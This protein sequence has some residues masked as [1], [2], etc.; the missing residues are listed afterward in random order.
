MKLEYLREL[1]SKHRKDPNYRLKNTSEEEFFAQSVKSYER[2]PEEQKK[3]INSSWVKMLI[4]EGDLVSSPSEEDKP[5]IRKELIE[6][7]FLAQTNL[8]FLCHLLERYS[9]TTLNTHEDICNDF[10]VQKDP[11][12]HTLESFANDYDQ[13]RKRRLLLVPRNGFK[14]S[15]DMADCVQYTICYPEVTILVMTGTLPLATEFVGEIREHFEM[16]QTQ[17]VDT[18]GKPKFKPRDMKNKKTGDITSSMFQVLFPEHCILPG[19]GKLTEFQTP[20]LVGSGDKEPTVR[21]ASIEQTLSGFHFGV[22]KLDDVVTNENSTTRT[23]IEAVNRQI[24][25]NRGM[26]NPYG[27]VDVIG[28]VVSTRTI[29]TARL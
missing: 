13:N 11:V 20:A 2:L 27:F 6:T 25:V 5:K 8:F 14:S 15:M 26:L 10:F 17:D 7:R 12:Y 19:T 21:A 23:R 22:L 24:S 3:Q 9:D 18:K 1:C 29:S 28:T 16:T 4:T